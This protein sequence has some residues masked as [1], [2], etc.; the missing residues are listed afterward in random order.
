MLNAR[1][2]LLLGRVLEVH[3]R[4]YFLAMAI[5]VSY[6]GGQK[7]GLLFLSIPSRLT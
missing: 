2:R 1:R 7:V 6:G 5:G 3:R 4:G